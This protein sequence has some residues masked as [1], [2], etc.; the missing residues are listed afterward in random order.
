MSVAS[1]LKNKAQTRVQRLLDAM[2]ERG[3]Q[4][5]AQTAAFLDGELIVDACAGAAEPSGGRSVRGDTLFPV[6]STGKGVSAT[7][8]HILAERGKL[9]YDTP[10]A[11]YWPEFAAGGKENV[12]LRHALGHM[13]GIPQMP[14]CRD[15]GEALDWELMCSRTAALAPLWPPG[16]KTYY[17]AVTFS[18]IIGETVRRV[19]GRPFA[20]FVEEEICRPLGIDSIFFGVPDSETWRVAVLERAAPK[21]GTPPP[22]HHNAGAGNVETLPGWMK[23][24]EDFMNMPEGIRSCLPGC[25]AVMSAMGIARHYAALAGEVDGVRL[26]SPE[27]VR[28]AT[29]PNCPAGAPPPDFPWSFGLG[30]TLYAAE[31]PRGRI[32]GHSGYGGSEGLVYTEERLSIGVTVNR[33]GAG[34]TPEIIRELR[35]A[36]G[37]DN[38]LNPWK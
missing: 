16:S 10:I 6:F 5:G 17:H 7:A 9:D 18:W 23:P 27:T 33:T 34:A 32:F 12:T 24:I 19:S 21:D 38:R 29:E 8:V 22:V 20:V 28:K 11:A 31:P 4:R 2:V 15:A 3:V 14:E 1:P 36:L 37:F 13:S 35:D 25:S 26:L 30:Y